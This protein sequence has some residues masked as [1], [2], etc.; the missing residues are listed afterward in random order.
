MTSRELGNKRYPHGAL[1][2]GGFLAILTLAGTSAVKLD[3]TT[4]TNERLLQE[5][6]IS[7]G[8][9]NGLVEDMSV[10]ECVPKKT[11]Y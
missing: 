1:W 5:P 3:G 4:A 9:P 11:V 10:G 6:Q 8:C 2:I 7:I